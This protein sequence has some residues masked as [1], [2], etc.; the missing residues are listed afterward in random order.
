MIIR[1]D[2]FKFTVVLGNTFIDVRAQ[3][4]YCESKSY[5]ICELRKLYNCL[6]NHCRI[7]NY[8]KKNIY[9]IKKTVIATTEQSIAEY[10]SDVVGICHERLISI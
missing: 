10:Y 9:K 7:E 4:N 8:N 3:G 1:L 5:S 6:I 2:S